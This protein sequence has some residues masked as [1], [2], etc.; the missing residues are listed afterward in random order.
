LLGYRVLQSAQRR[1]INMGLFRKPQRRAMGRVEHPHRD[2]NEHRIEWC[3]RNFAE[4][5]YIGAGAASPAR[6]NT[7]TIPAVPWI[8]DLLGIKG[9]TVG[10]LWRDCKAHRRR[11]IKL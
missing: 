6:Q 1:A 5:R 3:L 8:T 11:T 7:T 2:F 9:D 4:E 10:F